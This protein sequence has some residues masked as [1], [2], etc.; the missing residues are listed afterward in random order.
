MVV[1]IVHVGAVIACGRLSANGGSGVVVCVFDMGSSVV[2][3]VLC[4]C[5]WG[6]CRM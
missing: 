6:S 3:V 1:V 5:G 4:E 2:M